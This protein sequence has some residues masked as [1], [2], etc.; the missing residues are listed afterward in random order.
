MIL[1]EAPAARADGEP[2]IRLPH[3]QVSPD[4]RRDRLGQRGATVW[5][6]GLPASGKTEI[7]YALER[8]LF[9]QGRL[10]YVTDPD[11]GL[12]TRTRA[13][14]NSPRFT[15]E[16]ARRMTDMGF[17]NIYA[18]ASPQRMDREAVREA[19]GD[20]RFLE[21]HVATPLAACRARDRRGAYGPAHADPVFES[22]DK[23]HVT[24]S[25]VNST[26]DQAVENIIA[27]LE[28]RKLFD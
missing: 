10:A 23:P 9:N 15:P 27:A 22:S 5:L 21:V 6:M 3:T 4:E 14:G 1:E 25:L 16:V 12:S 7:A 17:I 11:D 26:L 19:V 20:A 13:D 8:R 2:E 24:V 18:F 28:E